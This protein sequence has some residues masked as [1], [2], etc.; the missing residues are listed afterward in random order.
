LKCFWL[1]QSMTA[2]NDNKTPGFWHLTIC[3]LMLP[4]VSRWELLSS[5]LLHSE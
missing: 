5:G 3:D 4:P 2:Q 1:D